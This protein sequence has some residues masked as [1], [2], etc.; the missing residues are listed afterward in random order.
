MFETFSFRFSNLFRISNFVFRISLLAGV[1]S[2]VHAELPSI[3]FDRLTP[4]GA[5]AGASVEAAIDVDKAADL[6]LVNR[7]LGSGA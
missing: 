6:E 3:R 5:A 7:I 1:V 4:L 2:S